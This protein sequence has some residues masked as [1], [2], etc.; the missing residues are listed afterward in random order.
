MLYNNRVFK[1][2]FREKMTEVI[3]KNN[4]KQEKNIKIKRNSLIINF[5]DNFPEESKEEEENEK[6]KIKIPKLNLEIISPIKVRRYSQPLKQ[7]S[8]RLSTS[9]KSKKKLNKDYLDTILCES[10][11]LMTIRKIRRCEINHLQNYC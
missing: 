10:K 1:D 6:K 4:Q 5:K 8:S 7:L 11:K 3:K 2:V 9:P